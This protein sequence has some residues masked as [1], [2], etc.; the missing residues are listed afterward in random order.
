MRGPQLRQARLRLVGL[1]GRS[2]QCLPMGQA[3]SFGM[4]KR[5]LIS[6]FGKERNGF[7]REARLLP[8]EDSPGFVG[9][10]R[11]IPHR[12]CPEL[13]PGPGWDQALPPLSLSQAETMSG[14][15]S[16]QPGAGTQEAPTRASLAQAAAHTWSRVPTHTQPLFSLASLFW[17]SWFSTRGKL[18]LLFSGG[19]LSLPRD[20]VLHLGAW[21]GLAF[22]RQERVCGD[23]SLSRGP[24][25]QP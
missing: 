9:A 4:G 25:T 19:F 16:A 2:A 15:H 3:Q 17:N 20:R 10:G 18:V 23:P 24:T 12:E 1:P 22:C 11:T 13:C 21:A 7:L 14:P 8:K 6:A 5:D